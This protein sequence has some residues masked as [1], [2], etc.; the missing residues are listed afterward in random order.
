MALGRKRGS[1]E[2]E[3][4]SPEVVRPDG[5]F[6][7]GYPG[8]TPGDFE[9]DAPVKKERR[10]RR[11]KGA[12]PEEELG[13]AFAE[14]TNP[15]EGSSPQ[16]QFDFL[17]GRWVHTQKVTR[18]RRVSAGVSAA[19]V[20]LVL[21][22]GA[23]GYLGASQ[24]AKETERE[25]DR[26]AASTARLGEVSQVGGR[27]SE[28]LQ[29]H[30]EQRR[31][32]I[33][34]AVGSEADY[35][36]VIADIIAARPPGIQL[37]SITFQPGTAPSVDATGNPVPG[38]QSISISVQGTGFQSVIDWI[39]A[40]KRMTTLTNLNTVPSGSP[41]GTFS[42]VTTAT[43]APTAASERATSLANQ[44]ATPGEDAA[45]VPGAPA[46]DAGASPSPSGASQ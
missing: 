18:A 42:I 35:N 46:P 3:L 1:D 14:D 11:S 2:D 37:Q 23:L 30:L 36:R 12:A 9:D 45:A 41:Q 26:L 5:G 25:Q 33:L 15:L 21:G 20:L 4:L 40:T 7:G 13:D 39:E 24:A 31:S 8:F 17:E 16:T 43:L 32:E 10:K 27:S 29:A 38:Q 22:V 28:E 34:T 44:L 19:L 6:G